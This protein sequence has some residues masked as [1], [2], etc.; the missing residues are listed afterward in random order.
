MNTFYDYGK[1]LGH[2]S[3]PRWTGGTNEPQTKPRQV[4]A[5]GEHLLQ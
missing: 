4:S 1:E 2:N 5:Y 3:F